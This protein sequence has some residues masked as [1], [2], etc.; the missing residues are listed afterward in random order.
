[1]EELIGKLIKIPTGTKIGVIVGAAVLIS[2]AN[3][4]V[5]PGISDI[6][7]QTD[8]LRRKHATLEAEFTKKQ[9]VANNLNQYKAQL[10]V[11]EQKLKEAL[12]EM[13]EEVRIDS[14]LTQFSE[15]AKK[16]GLSL[17]T[18][19][20]MAEAPSGDFYRIPIKMSV[21]GNYHEIAVFLDSVSKLKRIVNVSEIDFK[22]PVAIADKVVLTASYQATTFR[23]A[24]EDK[25]ASGKKAKGSK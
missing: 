7:D 9:Q 12:T 14:L 24:G 10:E 16:A 2:A 20:P 6:Y 5:L 21:S 25:K 13:P 18:L 22:Q 15:L 19:E 17:R 11:V 3:F 4:F 1:M 23:F 8:G